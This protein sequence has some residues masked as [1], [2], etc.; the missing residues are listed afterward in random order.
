[1][2]ITIDGRIFCA[3]T[4]RKGELHHSIGFITNAKIVAPTTLGLYRML[5]RKGVHQFKLEA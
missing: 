2:N 3:M 5:L 1:M 4:A